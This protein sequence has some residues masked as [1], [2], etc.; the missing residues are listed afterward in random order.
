MSETCVDAVEALRN[1]VIKG[2]LWS[3]VKVVQDGRATGVPDPAMGKAAE[4][5][6]VA[7]LHNAPSLFPKEYVE[8]WTVLAEAVKGL[9]MGARGDAGAVAATKAVLTW[10]PEPVR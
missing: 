9:Q 10:R 7:F 3:V 5:L 8:A 4:L 6:E 1:D 2:S